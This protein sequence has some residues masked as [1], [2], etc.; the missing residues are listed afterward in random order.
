MTE[1][2]HTIVV[3]AGVIGLAV[4]R[5]LA[6]DHG[7]VLLIERADGIGSETSSRNSEVIHA[8]MYYAAGS[9]KARSC[10]TG[11]RMLYDYC[12]ESGVEHRRTGKLIVATDE[13][14]LTAL[15]AIAARAETNGLMGEDEALTRIDAASAMAMEP[16]LRCVG[17]LLSPATGIIDTHGLM[18]SYLADAERAGATLV[19]DTEFVG[20]T[21]EGTGWRVRTRGADGEFE[22]SCEHLV[23]AAGLYAQRAAEHIDGLAAADIP[24]SVWLKGN[25]FAVTGKRPPF[26][27]LIYPVPSGGGLG[28]HLT[29]DLDGQVRFGPDTEPVPDPASTPDYRVNPRR[30]DVFYA[31]IRRYW[32]DLADDTLVPAYSGMRTKAGGGVEGNDFQVRGPQSHGLPGL[33]NLFGIESPGITASLA[34]ADLVASQLAAPSPAT[35]QK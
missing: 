10:V 5:R 29:K 35:M 7:E 28:V 19:T 1:H 2:V 17:A 20:A 27:R 24:A 14:Q 25:Y 18:L 15:D 33:V 26:Q 23:N 12:R 30:A 22:L 4:A 32:P 21:R 16:G 13:S 34:L 6:L 9:L 11:R 8:G 3:G 31:E